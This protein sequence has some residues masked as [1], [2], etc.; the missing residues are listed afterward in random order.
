MMTKMM[1][2]MSS[3][4]HAN[5]NDMIQLGVGMGMAMLT[6][7]AVDGIMNDNQQVRNTIL[8]QSAHS[9]T[10]SLLL[11]VYI[12]LSSLSRLLSFVTILTM[13]SKE[14]SLTLL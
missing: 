11:H 3:M 7:G 12:R 5:P 2:N 13:Y 6:T 1:G 10:H 14:P 4:D 8:S 9:F